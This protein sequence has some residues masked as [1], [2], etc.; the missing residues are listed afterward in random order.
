MSDRERVALAAL[1]WGLGLFLLLWS[2]D[3]IVEPSKTTEIF[4]FFYHL[5]LPPRAA[6]LVGALEALLSIA[7]ILGLWK[8]A[9][10]GLALAV[11][12]VSTMSTL[13][14]LLRPFGENHLFIAGIPVWTAFLALY[15]LRRHD[16][17][18]SLSR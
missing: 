17:L 15:L 1:R 9:V 11:H 4:A 8:R 12:T 16:T 18:W 13:P 14:I 6:P 2:A 5:P 3:K 10:Y 7:L